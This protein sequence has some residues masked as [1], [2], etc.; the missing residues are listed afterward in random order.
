MVIRPVVVVGLYS[1]RWAAV[2][3]G[4]REEAAVADL[5]GL[6]AEAGVSAEAAQGQIGR[7]DANKG[8][9]QQ[10]GS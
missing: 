2:A 9:S 5:A 8:I 10:A 3:V 7:R 4:P 1:F 6:A